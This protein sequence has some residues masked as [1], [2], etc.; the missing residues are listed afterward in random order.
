MPREKA[1]I[2]TRQVDESV[3]LK[4]AVAVNTNSMTY[5]APTG[6]LEK[7]MKEMKKLAEQMAHL[8]EGGATR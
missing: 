4:P 3:E 1:H 7:L 2:P 5:P 8:Q 6:T